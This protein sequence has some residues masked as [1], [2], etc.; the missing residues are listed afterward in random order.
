LE[1]KETHSIMLKNVAVKKP[2]VINILRERDW[3]GGK[4]GGRG[5][6]GGDG[7]G[8]G[9]GKGRRWKERGEEEGGK[10]EGREG[11]WGE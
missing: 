11:G 6:R 3:G 8:R 4:D 10:R 7:E 2:V 5:Y 1:V 9:R